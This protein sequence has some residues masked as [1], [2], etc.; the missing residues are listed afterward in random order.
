MKKIGSKFLFFVGVLA[1][2]GQAGC[3]GDAPAGHDHSH[4]HDEP[5]YHEPPHGGVG[6]TFGNE[7]AH[8]EFLVNPEAGTVTAWFFKPHME[9]YLRMKLESFE[10]LAKRDGEDAK[11]LFKA[12][13]NP[14]TGETVGDTSEFLAK[15]DWLSETESFDAVLP[16]ITVLGKVYRN[17]AF[18]YPNG[19]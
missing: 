7:D 16:E 9:Q 13:A 14:V 19:N 10:V 3:G 17:V 1:G 2:L 5:H 8:I 12:V 6:V 18:K 4:T 11:L 15:A